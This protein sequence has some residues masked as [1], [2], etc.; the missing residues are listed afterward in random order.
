MEHTFGDRLKLLRHEN[1]ITI[2]ELI[3]AVEA[4]YPELHLSKPVISRY[5]NN[6][7]TPKQFTIIEDLAEFFGVSVNYITGKSDDKYG[8]EVKYKEVPVL[9]TIA[10][11]A[12]ILAQE[13]VLG[14]EYINPNSDID[15]CLK[16]K[17]DSMIGARIY[18]GDIVFIHCQPEVENGEIA[19]VQ[20]D[21]EIAT[22]KRV[23]NADGNIILRAE[24]SLYKDMIFSKKDK[25]SIEI[26]GKAVCF[27]SEVR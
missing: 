20:I 12:P 3:D 9:G 4:K 23:Y 11:G 6:V 15:F 21:G 18:D 8:E 19:A 10:A 2:Q 16:V 7:H 1:D 13:D 17:G 26:L 27:K 25:K 14:F 5:E 22:L 24:N